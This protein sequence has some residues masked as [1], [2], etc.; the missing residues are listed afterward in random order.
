[1]AFHDILSLNVRLLKL[2]G[3]GRRLPFL[4]TRSV[5]DVEISFPFIPF[6]GSFKY[7]SAVGRNFTFI[8]GSNQWIGDDRKDRVA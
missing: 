6:V 8:Q 3:K 1:M 4:T 2:R 7:I 5:L